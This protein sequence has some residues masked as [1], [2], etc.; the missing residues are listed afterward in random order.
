MVWLGPDTTSAPDGSP[1]AGASGYR[2]DEALL[3]GFSATHLSGAGCPAFGD[4]PVL[5]FVGTLPGDPSG[6]TVPIIKGSEEAA[7]GSYAVR[8]GNGV[9][10]SMSA[11]DRS[12]LMRFAFGSGR[13]ARLLVKADGSLAGTTA[14]SARVLS[15]REIAVRATS[16]GFCGSP[17]TYRVFVV[18][19]F[20]EPFGRHGTWPGGVWVNVDRVTRVQVGVSFV[21]I[22]GATRNLEADRLGWSVDRLATRSADVWKTELDRIRTRG[23]TPEGR[24]L[25]DS[26]LYRVLQHPSTVSDADGRYLGFDGTV[27]RLPDGERQLSGFGGWDYYRTHAPLLAW[28]RPDVASEVV[29]SLLRAGREGGRLPKWPLVADETHIMNGDSAAPVVATTHAFGARDFDLVEALERLVRQGSTVRDQDGFEPRPGL[30]DFLADGYVPEIVRER[31]LDLSHGGSTTLEYA[32]D[33][34]AISRLAAAAGRDRVNGVHRERSGSWRSLLDPGRR[35]LVAR[36]ADGD[37]PPPEVDVNVCCLGFEEGNSLQYTWGG[38][39][40][41]MSGLL[42]ALGTPAEAADRLDDFFAQL[43]AGTAPYAWM[44]NQPSLATP[45]TYYWLGLPARGQD[46]VDRI[47]AA[48]WSPGPEGIPGNDDLGA[49][50]AWYVWTSLGLYPVTPGTASLA[51]GVPAFT[52]IVVRPSWGGST[53][54]RRSGTGAHVLGARV[55]GTTLTRSW[56]AWGP[57][58]RARHLTIATTDALQPLWGTGTTAVPPSYAAGRRD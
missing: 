51:V 8:L 9:R 26:A 35:Q 23:G 20:A 58:Q 31:G 11:G 27:R 40:H 44:G 12:G 53:T 16:G 5:P 48:L 37:F 10:A 41:D 33:D 28:I 54:I 17:N 3:R 1:S 36:D 49:L 45:W 52:R 19:R 42:A 56:L 7:P 32:L 25:F 22:R 47:R 38:V 4:V 21:S 34:F 24:R 46:V 15:K 39:P 57:K 29:R 14:S 13:R 50:S 6:A 55:D 18:L 2:D 43:N 30:A